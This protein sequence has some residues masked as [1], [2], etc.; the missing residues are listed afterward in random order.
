MR[1]DKFLSD[2]SPMGRKE[3]KQHIKKGMVSVNGNV[4]KDPGTYVDETKDEVAFCGEVISY[5]KFVYLMLNKPEGYVSAT[6]DKHYKVVTD[7]VDEEYAHF[8]VFPVGRL[9]IDTHGLLLLTNDGD[10]AHKL[11]SPKS[12][13]PKTYYVKSE[14]EVTDEDIK[15]FEEGIDL[16]D[17]KTIGGKCEIVSDDKKECYLTI[18]EGKF[19]QVKRMFEAVGNKVTYLKRISMGGLTLDESLGEGDLREL[20]D[21]EFEKLTKGI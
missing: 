12:H 20:T 16:G 21:D 11:L 10:L 3:I 4:I 19:H 8:E 15:V 6:Y 2:A 18:F 13:V 5:K 17:F 7:L 1:L 14:K 9:D